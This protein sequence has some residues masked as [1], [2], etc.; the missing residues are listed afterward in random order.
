MK[1]I[2]CC[3]CHFTITLLQAQNSQLYYSGKFLTS[4]DKEQNFLKVYN[5]NSGIYELTDEKGFAIIAA[6]L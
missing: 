6:K 1:K 2:I 3:C 5:K 4:K